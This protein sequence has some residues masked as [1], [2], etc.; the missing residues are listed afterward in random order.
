MIR[1]IDY[2]ALALAQ[3]GAVIWG[4]IAFF[5]FNLVKVLFGDMTLLSRII[6]AVIGIAGLYLFTLY[7]RIREADEV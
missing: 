5:D 7:G 1:G 2:I 4:L 6:Y 3:I